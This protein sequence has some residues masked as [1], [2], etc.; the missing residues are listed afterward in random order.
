LHAHTQVLGKLS[1]ALAPPEWQLVHA[2]LRLTV[3]GWETLLLPPPD[4]SGGFAVVLDLR[5]HEAVVEH[6]DG[7][8]R[9]IPLTPNRPVGEVT[10]E[11]LE[12]VRGLVGP[13]SINLEPQEVPWTVR[14]DEDTEHATYD[15]AQVAAYHQVA[16]RVALVLAAARAPFRGRATAVIAWWGS[17]DLAVS[18]YNGQT[19]QPPANDFITRNSFNDEHIA[20]GWWPGDDRYPKPAFYAYATPAPDGYDQGSLSPP[21]SRWEP[22]LGEF[23]YDW[24]DVR[25]ADDPHAAALDFCRSAVEHSCRSCGWDPALSKSAQATP[26]PLS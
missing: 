16:T 12:A 9:R 10:R 8:S 21:E 5:T 18:L 15:T 6:S 4:G 19:M 23:I 26:S 20:F 1:V 17:F 24:D 3:R 25:A 14:L 2:G 22:S 13:V 7:R 11:V